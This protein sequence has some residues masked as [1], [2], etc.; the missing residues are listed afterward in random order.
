MVSIFK[1]W[2]AWNTLK[3]IECPSNVF[4][5]WIIGSWVMLVVLIAIPGIIHY[6]NLPDIYFLS[7]PIVFFPALLITNYGS[8]V[9]NH[10][11]LQH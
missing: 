3:K 7:I 5:A 11:V 6:Y 10:L 4:L 1:P 2:A 9:I 8:N